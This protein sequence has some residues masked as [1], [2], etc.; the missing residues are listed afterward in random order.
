MASEDREEI[1]NGR[2]SR[3]HGALLLFLSSFFFLLFLS[4][5]SS[6]KAPDFSLEQNLP[7][8]PGGYVYLLAEKD[9]LPVLSQLGFT[10]ISNIQ[11]QVMLHLTEFVAAAIYMTPNTHYRLAAWGEYP[12]ARARMALNSSREWKK[13]RSTVVKANYWHSA[14][15]GVS[16][17][18][19]GGMALAATSPADAVTS[20]DP[21][22]VAPGTAIPEGFN[23][24]RKE[25]MLACWLNEPGPAINAKLGEMGI[26][27]E[28]PADQVFVSLYPAEN[29]RYTAHLQIRVSSEI[30]ARGLIMVFG[31]A[32]NFL[33]RQVDRDNP[34]ALLS[35]ILFANPPEQDGSNLNITTAPLTVHEIALLLKLFA[36]E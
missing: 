32:R 13:H 31:I 28:L 33:P 3:R 35:S 12:A 18:I 15:S 21:Y 36:I 2:I 25:A 1:M 23:E 5:A 6:P 4:C 8:E 24:F 9:A 22:T 17:A 30:Q 34:I 14:Q 7:L 29:Q 19:T 20:I 27:I 16:V 26:P 11:F 10:N